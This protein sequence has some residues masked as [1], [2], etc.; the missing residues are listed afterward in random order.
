M[1]LEEEKEYWKNFDWEQFDLDTREGV[2]AY[3]E[4]EKERFDFRRRL[5]EAEYN[6]IDDEEEY[7]EDDLADLTIISEEELEDSNNP[8]KALQN[9][10]DRSDE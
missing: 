9:T 8:F 7:A 6:S 5:E 3:G 4:K 2:L 1:T 10:M